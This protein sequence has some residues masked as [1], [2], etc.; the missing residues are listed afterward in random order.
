MWHRLRLSSPGPPP[1]S[2]QETRD[3]FRSLREDLEERERQRIG[4]LV[5][6]TLA[7][8]FGLPTDHEGR[9]GFRE[10][11]N[12]SAAFQYDWVSYDLA[13]PQAFWVQIIRDPFAFGASCT[14]WNG[15][16]LTASYLQDRLRD[17]VGMVQWSR[18][19]RDTSRYY[20]FRYEDLIARPVGVPTPLLKRH[21]HR[22]CRGSVR[23]A[24][25]CPWARL[26]ACG[27]GRVR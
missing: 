3:M 20:E 9:W 7:E 1:K 6:R 10:L 27:A 14:A 22:L 16:S 25:V 2:E 13:F 11:W 8:A 4:R 17:W 19:R 12:G 21:S 18:K 24:G 23:F 15:D 5:G 26:C